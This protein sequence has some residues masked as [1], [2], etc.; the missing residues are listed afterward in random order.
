[1][2]LYQKHGQQLN[3]VFDIFHISYMG[4][5]VNN[6][7]L[8]F[9]PCQ[10][11]CCSYLLLIYMTTLK[12]LIAQREALEKQIT[13]LRQTE[14]A[15]A[16]AKVRALITEFELTESDIFGTTT[17]VRKAKVMKSKVAAKYREPITGKE[18]SGRGLAPKWLQGKN[19]ADY[20]IA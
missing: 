16:I 4:I 5:G 12:D 15:D 9:S 17:K 7:G 2:T 10:N 8:Q 14:H 3:E 18:W 19:K 11:V 6:I 13:E 20:L 1:M